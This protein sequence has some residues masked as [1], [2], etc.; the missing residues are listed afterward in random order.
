LL[1]LVVGIFI[2]AVGIGRRDKALDSAETSIVE[3]REIAAEMLRAQ[4]DNVATDKV[5]TQRLDD[6]QRRLDRLDN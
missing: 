4:L 1:T 3:L 2:V 5:Q 6:L